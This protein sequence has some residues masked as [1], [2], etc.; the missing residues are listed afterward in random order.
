MGRDK[1]TLEWQGIP[2][3][4]RVADALAACVTPVRVVVRPGQAVPVD[5]PRIEDRL[6]VRAP[7]SG[8]HAAL[9]ACRA[10]A[11]LVAACDVPELAPAFL[12]ALLALVPARGGPDAVVPEGD[13]GPEPLVAVYR[14]AVIP[15]I[16]ARVDRGDLSLRGL[17]DEIDTLRVPVEQLRPF[18]P[19]LRSLRNVNRPEDLTDHPST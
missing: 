15:T 9:Q 4:E 19:A 11:V 8:I 17:L 12:L 10:S 6:E 13:D 14:P 2:M 3:A 16:E 18:D 1:A 5:L 7:V